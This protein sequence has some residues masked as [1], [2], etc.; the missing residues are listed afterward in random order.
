MIPIY[1]DTAALLYT[2]L[3]FGPKKDPDGNAYIVRKF[4]ERLQKEGVQVRISFYKQYPF[5]YPF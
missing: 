1:E 2:S 3:E 5:T 4:G